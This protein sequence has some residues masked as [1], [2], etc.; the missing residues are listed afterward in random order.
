MLTEADFTNGELRFTYC[1]VEI[2]YKF[3]P[4]TLHPA[5]S[6]QGLTLS[7]EDSARLFARDT[8]LSPVIVQV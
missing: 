6:S 7:K 2:V 5:P 4:S 3:T 8:T 1:G